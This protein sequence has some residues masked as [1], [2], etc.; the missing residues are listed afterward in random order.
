MVYS[1]NFLD[2][3]LGE[4]IGREII[5][6]TRWIAHDAVARWWMLYPNSNI[7]FELMP[8]LMYYNLLFVMRLCVDAPAPRRECAIVMSVPNRLVKDEGVFG[9]GLGFEISAPR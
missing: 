4:F 7:K 8:N 1:P 2:L 9:F 6:I 3:I 5:A